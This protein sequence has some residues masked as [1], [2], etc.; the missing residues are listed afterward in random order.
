[1][2]RIRAGEGTLG[3]SHG[4][5]LHH[6][7]ELCRQRRDQS[8]SPGAAHQLKIGKMRARAKAQ[9]QVCGK[10]PQRAAAMMVL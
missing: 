8:L 3:E 5:D 1:M 10:S 6:I 7:R 2:L 4:A 9:G